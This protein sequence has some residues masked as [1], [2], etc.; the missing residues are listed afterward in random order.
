MEESP[1]AAVPE[2]SATTAKATL[3]RRV[4]LRRLM[5]VFR[6]AVP[7]ALIAF[8]L[9]MVP[10]RDVLAS[11]ATVPLRA[12]AGALAAIVVTTAIATLRWRVLF[13]ACGVAKKPAFLEL[14]RAYWIGAFY[15]TYLPGGLGGDVVRAIATRRVV[16]ERGLPAALAIVFLERTLGLAGLLIL[17]AASF[18][19]FP[20][21]GIANVMLWSSLG[22]FVAAAAVIAIVSGPRLAP[23]LPQPLGRVAAAL[24]TIESPLLFA[25]A[26]LLSVVTQFGGVV[27]GHL[28]IS[29]ISHR[30]AFTDSLVILPLVNAAQ[31]F[32]LTVGGA[33]V[34]EAGFVLFYGLIQVSKADAL[35]GSLVAGA[36]MYLAN[37]IGGILHAARPLTVDQDQSDEANAAAAAAASASKS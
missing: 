1:I 32:P 20:L 36:L 4:R 22:L 28:V 30:V 3:Q 18:S 26:L 14:L 24:P 13:S 15:N 9:S 21:R 37:A 10:L 17:V 2:Q 25:V 11:A 34:R 29:G 33:G 7:V 16:G 5:L 31:Y 8:L 35:A 27:F 23:Y 12:I 6:F 19:C